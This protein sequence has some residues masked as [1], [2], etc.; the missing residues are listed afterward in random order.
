MTARAYGSCDCIEVRESALDSA[1]NVRA[2]PPHYAC[3]ELPSSEEDAAAGHE[4]LTGMTRA[5]DLPLMK[6]CIV[7]SCT[8]VASRF[9]VCPQD[10]IRMCIEL[11]TSRVVMAARRSLKLSYLHPGTTETC[12]KGLAQI[13][14]KCPR[15]RCRDH[16][17]AARP[18][19]R[20]IVCRCMAS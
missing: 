1:W 14:K 5:I 6:P 16:G 20:F 12:L 7:F 19:R 13:T 11:V 15:R 17:R 2:N 3:S 18:P 9:T 10:F 4:G 8:V